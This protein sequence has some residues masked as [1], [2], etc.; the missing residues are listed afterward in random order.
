MS[1]LIDNQQK[2]RQEKLRELIQK[3]HDGAD[4]KVVQEEFNRHF[5]DVSPSEISAME[6][7]LVKDG[8]PITEIQRLCDVH[9]AVFKGSIQ[10][11]HHPA[12]DVS[13]PGHPVAFLKA[14]NQALEELISQRVESDLARFIKKPGTDTKKVLAESLVELQ[15]IDRHYS[16]KENL[17]FSFLEKH[18]VT[19]PPKVMWG[20]DDE[21]RAMIK[22]AVSSI[23]SW[24]E[25]DL[26]PGAVADQITEAIDKTR[27]MVFKEEHILLPMSL[28]KLSEDEWR[29][30]ADDSREIGF[31]LIAP[32]PAWPDA[33]GQSKSEEGTPA[34]SG[35]N[36]EA[37]AAA[38]KV[39]LPSGVFTVESLTAML[40]TLPFDM[41]FVDHNDKVG[42]FSQGRERIFDR[43]LSII[44]RE[45]VNCHPPASM[46]IVE[47]ILSDFKSGRREQADF[48]IKMGPKYVLIRYYA[49]R[50]DQGQYLGTLEVTQDIAPIQAIEGEK[51]LLEDN[52]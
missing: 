37:Q 28:E 8:L 40:N 29:Q 30:I 45:V 26:P 35:K 43:N 4:M 13:W 33:P 17:L 38:G 12:N 21:I 49:V 51:R 27:E 47:Q 3:L 31:C 22:N 1:E 32:P 11:I 20:V 10:D 7:A 46:H 25:N 41:T 16:K 2:R 18:D 19:A 23:S 52:V 44:G 50:D 15:K 48:W 5:S 36:I 14:E 6:Q 42:Y 39:S 24:P 34:S 9:A